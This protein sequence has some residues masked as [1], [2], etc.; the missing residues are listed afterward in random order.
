MTTLD[1]HIA[2]PRRAAMD[3]ST[4]AAALTAIALVVLMGIPALMAPTSE[5][6]ATGWHGNAATS[7]S[8]R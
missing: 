4:L 1:F 7:V 3:R 6:P 8:L 5:I 2:T